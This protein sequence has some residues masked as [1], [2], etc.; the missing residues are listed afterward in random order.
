MDEKLNR[1]EEMIGTLI[2]M[3]G[4]ISVRVEEVAHDLKETKDTLHTF[5]SETDYVGY[6]M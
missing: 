4:N 6:P 5:R 3:V 2:Q 1:L